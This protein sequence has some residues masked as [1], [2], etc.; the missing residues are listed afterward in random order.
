[1]IA[2]TVVIPTWVVAYVAV[3][4]IGVWLSFV[5]LGYEGC[6]DT[7]DGLDVILAI[8]W[9]VV[10]WIAVGSKIINLLYDWYVK[11]SRHHSVS[12]RRVAACL[13]WI[14]LPIRPWRIGKMIR[15]HKRNER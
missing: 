6:R 9:P 3:Y 11:W 13:F 10:I 4:L 8:L 1:M 5:F 12:L 14:A 15:N 7:V 2:A